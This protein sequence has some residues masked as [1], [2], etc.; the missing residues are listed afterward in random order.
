MTRAL[1]LPSI[2]SRF[3]GVLQYMRADEPGTPPTWRTMGPNHGECS[4]I[5]LLEAVRFLLGDLRVTQLRI[6]KVSD[7]AP[8]AP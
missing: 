4:L 6:I 7:V 1:A 2:A 8:Q 5:H 3:H